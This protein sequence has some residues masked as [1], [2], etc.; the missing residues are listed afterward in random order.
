MCCHFCPGT[1]G[2]IYFV[3]S[4]DR[5]RIED[6][7]EGLDKTL[8]EDEM[9]DAVVLVFADEQDLSNAMMTTVV[10]QVIMEGFLGSQLRDK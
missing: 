1:N 8:N 4:N 2:L 5:D 10:L 9:R 6:A 3:N 7:K